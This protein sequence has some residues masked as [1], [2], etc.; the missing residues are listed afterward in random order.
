MPFEMAQNLKGYSFCDSNI[1][2][3]LCKRN[4]N[5]EIKKD[6]TT[7]SKG[8]LQNN[9]SEYVRLSHKF[10]DCGRKQK[11]RQLL[12]LTQNCLKQAGRLAGIL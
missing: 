4:M 1:I 9:D 3:Y 12:P 8:I 7:P 5:M 11:K 10:Q 6:L 2:D